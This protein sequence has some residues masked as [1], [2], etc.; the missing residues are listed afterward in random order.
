MKLF[1]NIIWVMSVLDWHNCESQVVNIFFDQDCTSYNM[2][3]QLT[4]PLMS[5]DF[6]LEGVFLGVSSNFQHLPH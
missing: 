3:I 4:L 5:L 1:V 6:E 2:G